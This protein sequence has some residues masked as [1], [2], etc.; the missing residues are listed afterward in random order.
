LG[1]RSENGKFGTII[2][3]KASQDACTAFLLQRSVST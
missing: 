3:T 2:R 1:A